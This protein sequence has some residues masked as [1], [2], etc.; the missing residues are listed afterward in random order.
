MNVLQHFASGRFLSK[1]LCSRHHSIEDDFY[2]KKG[3]VSFMSHPLGDYVRTSTIA[4][5]KARVRFRIH[6]N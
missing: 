2:S 6:Q 1:K 3:K 4:R 5:W